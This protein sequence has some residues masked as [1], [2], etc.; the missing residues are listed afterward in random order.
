MKPINLFR[1]KTLFIIIL[2]FS[3]FTSC[4]KV[5]NENKPI[6]EFVKDSIVCDCESNW[7]PHSQTPAPEEGKGS[8]FDVSSTTNCIF[9]QWS[10]QKFLWLTKPDNNNNP[11]FLNNLT[12][13]TDAMAPITKQTGVSIVLNATTDNE[14]AGSN[15]ILKANPAYSGNNSNVDYTVYYSIHSNDIMMNASKNYLD[16]LNTQKISPNNLKTFPVGSLELKVS[17]IDANAIPSNKQQNYFITTAAFSENGSTF[18]NKQVALL[19]MHVVGVVINHPEFI[20]ATFEHKDLGPNYDWANN[21]ATTTDEKLL[22]SKGTTTGLDGIT[23]NGTSVVTSLKAFD[24]F[25]YGVPKTSSNQFMQTCQQEPENFNNIQNINTCISS[26]LDDVWNNYFYNGSIWINTD[27]MS[28]EQQAQTIVNLG[29]GLGSAIPGA[30]ARGS[31]NNANITMETYT[32][33]FNKTISEINNTNLANCFSCHNSVNR[34]SSTVSY[35]SPLYISHVFNAYIKRNNGMS[36]DEINRLKD[37][38]HVL[39]FVKK[40]LK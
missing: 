28:P 38:E 33:T 10:W 1:L 32:Q 37:E 27:G 4:K 36:R 35:K 16:S 34:I 20:W 5:Q 15:G 14:Q 13:V 23:W 9:H 6:E 25:Q 8:P 12:Q 26:K 7:F 31:L 21:Q 29:Y 18:T 30:S 3:L 40:T 39:R 24:L 2:C 22:F 19:G 11:L 17:W